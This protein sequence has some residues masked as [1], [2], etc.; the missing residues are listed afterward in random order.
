MNERIQ[1]ILRTRTAAIED[2]WKALLRVEAGREPL[3]NPEALAF[4]VPTA[5]SRLLALVGSGRRMRSVGSLARH[6]CAQGRNPY[7]VFYRAGE[8]AILEMLVRVHAET[9]LLE[10]RDQDVT[11]V[12][13]AIHAAG[14]DDIDGFC[15]ICSV[16][17]SCT[18]RRDRRRAEAAMA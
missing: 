2:R 1:S 13:A 11:D 7:L 9:Q 14:M 16:S 6:A 5:L 17:E 18:D 10:T 3:A 8:Q 15:G 12:Y 4:W